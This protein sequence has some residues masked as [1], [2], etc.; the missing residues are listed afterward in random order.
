MKLIRR[1]LVQVGAWLIRLGTEAP[2]APTLQE[3]ARRLV[4]RQNEKWP[5]RDGECK[6]TAVYAQLVNTFPSTSKRAISRAI[7]EALP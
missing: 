3:L 6:R 7:E 1:W 5:E 4:L 2:S